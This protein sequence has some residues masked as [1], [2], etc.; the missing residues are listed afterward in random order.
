[1]EG[2]KW[3]SFV[4]SLADVFKAP[5]KDYSIKHFKVEEKLTHSGSKDIIQI[6]MIIEIEKTAS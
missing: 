2:I 6:T 4:E 5:S 1:M 3:N